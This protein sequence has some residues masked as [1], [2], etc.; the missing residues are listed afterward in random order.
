M[1]YLVHGR[2]RP[3]RVV[4]VTRSALYLTLDGPDAPSLSMITADAVRVPNAVVLAVSAT[5]SPFKEIRVGRSA[6]LGAGRVTVDALEVVAGSTWTPPRPRFQDAI[7]ALERVQELTGLVD[8]MALPMPAMLD[9]PVSRLMCAFGS[10]DGPAVEAAAHQLVGLG[11]GLTPS[12]DDI[13]CG[14]L[15]SCHALAAWDDHVATVGAAL[16]TVAVQG[17][18]RTSFVSAVLLSH[19]ARGEVI[20][21]VD[22]L[23]TALE[24]GAELR[25]PLSELVAVG[26]HSGSDLARGAMLG[27]L[28]G[29]SSIAQ[30]GRSLACPTQ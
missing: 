22:T 6:Y 19:A 5:H 24:T 11:P 30:E 10:R 15:T 2:P 9:A 14:A 17:R 8:E 12:G 1:T 20:P 27:L 16:A 28:T 29:Q 18:S 25:G 21:E 4:A 7:T 13:V 23:L 3:A 26:H